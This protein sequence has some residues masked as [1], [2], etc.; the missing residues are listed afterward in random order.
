MTGV[1]P[2]AYPVVERILAHTGST[3]SQLMGRADMLQALQPALF[4]SAQFGAITV[5]D[6]LA[7]LKKPG[8]DPRPVFKAAR[9]N[10]GVQDI[11]DL[12]VGMVLEGTVSKVAAFGAFVDLGVHQDGLV[13]VSQLSNRFVK[14]ARDVVRTGAIV[15]VRVLELDL[16]RQR[17]ALTMRLDAPVPAAGAAGGTRRDASSQRHQTGRRPAAEPPSAT[18]MASAFAKLGR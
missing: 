18:A 12:K 4:A 17:I 5:G 13:H 7:E 15:T 10:D 3:V 6:I 11:A 8:R 1:H 9:L 2:E 14:D 16:A